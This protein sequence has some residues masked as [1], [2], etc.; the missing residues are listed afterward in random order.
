MAN[1]K[2][3]YVILDLGKINPELETGTITD[4]MK[5]S[6]NYTGKQLREKLKEIFE[7]KKPVLCIFGLESVVN[8]ITSFIECKYGDLGL[9]LKLYEHIEISEEDLTILA[10]TYIEIGYTY[11]DSIFTYILRDI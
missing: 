11:N 8:N 7:L 6:S 10:H 3:G 9:T 1:L 4:D 5:F 2:G